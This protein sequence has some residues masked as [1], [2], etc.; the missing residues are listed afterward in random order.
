MG[1]VAAAVDIIQETVVEAVDQELE[2]V[3]V[4]VHTLQKTEL[5]TEVVEVV[6]QEMVLALLLVDTQQVPAA[7]V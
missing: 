3:V 7:Q 2:K 4:A 5:R 1:L 6:V